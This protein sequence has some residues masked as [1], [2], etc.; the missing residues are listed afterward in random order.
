MIAKEANAISVYLSV[1][2]EK[3]EEH[4]VKKTGDEESRRM[5]CYV[6]PK[7][8]SEYTINVRLGRQ[9]PW[10]KDFIAE[11]SIGGQATHSLHV[12]RKWHRN[13][14]METYFKEDEDGDL[15]ECQLN[16][17]RIV[18]PQ[19][20]VEEGNDMLDDDA[21]TIVVAVSRAEI[22]KVKPMKKTISQRVRGGQN[23]SGHSAR[24]TKRA[25]QKMAYNEEPTYEKGDSSEVPFVKF[26]F[27]VRTHQYLYDRGLIEKK[28]AQQ[29]PSQVARSVRIKAEPGLELD[30]TPSRAQA[31]GSYARAPK[32]EHD[33]D[34][35]RSESEAIKRCRMQ[36]QRIQQLEDMIRALTEDRLGP[37]RSSMRR[38]NNRRDALSIAP[39]EAESSYYGWHG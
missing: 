24:S 3:L 11:P 29:H 35:I 32:R 19:N 8:H 14:A 16:F 36:E 31:Y 34:N 6:V 26:I 33:E 22:D 39:S 2:G 5:E 4:R 17:G 10:P 37:G 30:D 9:T 27:K 23:Q 25:D 21:S 12:K 7:P 13:H 20:E 18:N 38:G 15:M 1:D 28:P